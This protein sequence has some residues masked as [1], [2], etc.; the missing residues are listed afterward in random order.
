MAFKAVNSSERK[1]PPASSVKRRAQCGVDD[2][3]SAQA[4]RNAPEITPLTISVWRKPNQRK[5]VEAVNFIKSAPAAVAK[6]SE[7][8]WNGGSQKRMCKRSGSKKGRSSM[9]TRKMRPPAT[10]AKKVGILRSL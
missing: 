5:A 8:D 7:P 10:P 9:P 3:N 4:A 2:V 6:V 1:K